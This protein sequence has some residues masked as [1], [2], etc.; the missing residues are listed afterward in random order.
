MLKTQ[1]ITKRYEKVCE[2]HNLFI[3]KCQ[4][5]GIIEMEKGEKICYILD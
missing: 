1:K 4:K 5:E 3:N 2:V